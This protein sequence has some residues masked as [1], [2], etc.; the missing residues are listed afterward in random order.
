MTSYLFD[1]DGTLTPSLE[2]ME[3]SFEDFFL[4]WMNEKKVFLVGGSDKVKVDFQIPP[5]VQSKCGGIFCC[6]GNELWQNGEITYQNEFSPPAGLTE[7]LIINQMYGGFPVKAKVGGRG[8]IFEF[9]SGM[10]NFTTIGR[11]AG[12]KERERYFKWDKKHGE[13]KSIAEEVERKFPELEVRI[14]G[15]ISIDIQPKGFNKSQATKWVRKNTPSQMIYIGDKCTY[16]GNDYDACRDLEISGDG[17]Y[18]N[19]DDWKETEG[20]L[21]TL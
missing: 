11:N 16:G 9:R 20:L 13:R 1:I 5:S 8:E 17:V 19:V 7:T 4:S 15:K 12:F 3:E 6:M 21:K 10:L 2:K 18:Y 14:G